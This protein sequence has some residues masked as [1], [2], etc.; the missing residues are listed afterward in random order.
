MYADNEMNKNDTLFKHLLKKL[1]V[2]RKEYY[3]IKSFMITILKLQKIVI[4]LSL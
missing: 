1:L 3:I 4:Y 2:D